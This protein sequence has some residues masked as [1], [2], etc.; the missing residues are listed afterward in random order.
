MAINDPTEI[1]NLVQWHDAS[2][3]ASITHSTGDVTVLAAQTGYG[4][5]LDAVTGTPRTGDSTLNGLNVIVFDGSE[6]LKGSP[7]GGATSAV[8]TA[9][10]VGRI[11]GSTG[12][13]QFLFSAQGGDSSGIVG[14]N[15]SNWAVNSTNI[16][17]S[18][19]P[20]DTDAHY[21]IYV[22][23]T[24][25]SRL[26]IDGVEYTLTGDPGSNGYASDGVWGANAYDGAFLSGYVA[27]TGVYSRVLNGTEIADLNAYLALKW[28]GIGGST[29][30]SKLLLLG[31]G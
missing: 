2:D 13:N 29:G 8:F 18:S 19:D 16:I 9:F 5:D 11:T 22:N 6:Q 21:F 1:T 14:I 26:W 15:G 7:I 31:V 27:E 28:F 30:G 3:T 24:T 25:S 12:G 10:C 4:N 17:E 23:N 20:T